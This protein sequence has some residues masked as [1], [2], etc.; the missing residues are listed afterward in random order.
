[1]P[2]HEMS[3]CEGLV[4]T[5]EAQ[6]TAQHFTQV[7][8]VWLEIGALATIEPEAMRF[9]F[10]IVARGTLAEDA[11]LITEVVDGEAWCM[12]C[13]ARVAVR[14]HGDGCPNCGSY[15]LQILEGQQMRVRQLEVS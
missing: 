6:A 11:E 9:N 5:L 14:R 12:Q 7:H 13:C 4:Q 10:P 1:M 3:L 8:K 15:Q 2:M